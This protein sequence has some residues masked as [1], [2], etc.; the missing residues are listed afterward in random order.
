MSLI[1]DSLKEKAMLDRLAEVG[2][3]PGMDFGWSDLDSETREA[4][5]HGFR[6]GF[7]TVKRTG[8]EHLQNVNGW[9]SFGA[10]PRGAFRTDWLSR[11]ALAD[12]GW[13]GSDWIG[14]HAAFWAFTD[15]NDDPLDGS[16]RYTITFDVDDLP[17][18]TQFWS[19]P[20]YDT[21]GYF[22]DNELDRYSI[23]SFLL[24]EGLLHV[25]DDQLVIHVQHD[26][27]TDPDAAKNWLP[28]PEGGFRFTARFYGPRW[29]L[30]D[31]SYEMP[32]VVPRGE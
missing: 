11:A 14:S 22:V 10:P 16:K 6:T 28:A 23:N 32:P 7:E 4:L 29:S 21:Q 1:D 8:R 3:G 20:I 15:P 24:K 26:R 17:P 2:I 9:M 31:G 5:T 30:I 12:F 19:I 18:V 13:A 27:P 25:E